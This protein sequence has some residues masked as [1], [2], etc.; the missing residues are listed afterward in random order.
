MSEDHEITTH[1]L[2]LPADANHYGTL[3]AGSLLK[4]GLEAAYAAATRGVGSKANL[5]LRRVLSVECRRAVPVGALVEIQGAILQV[6]QCHIVV[7]IVGMPLTN[8]DVPWM[9]GLFGFVQ[10]NEKGL[11]A[12]LPEMIRTASK[13]T[14][15]EPLLKRLAETKTRGATAEWLA[16]RAE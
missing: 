16:A 10:V 11:P 2:I 13:K 5:M 9:D 1:R 12:E 6:R 3:Y 4:Y 7:G 8:E 14:F 15:W